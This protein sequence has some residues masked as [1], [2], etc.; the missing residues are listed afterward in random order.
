VEL[1]A[2]SLSRLVEGRCPQCKQYPAYRKSGKAREEGRKED[3]PKT[4]EWFCDQCGHREW[5]KKA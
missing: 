1:M 3:G 4:E 2:H 5:R